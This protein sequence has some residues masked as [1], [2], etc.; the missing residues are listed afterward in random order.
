MDFQI[1]YQLAVPVVSSDL[2][3]M[4]LACALEEDDGVVVVACCC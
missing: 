4:W 2:G 3:W 1:N